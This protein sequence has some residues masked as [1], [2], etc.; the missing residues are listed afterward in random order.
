M[1]TDNPPADLASQ[2]LT[3]R[4][5]FEDLPSEVREGQWHFLRVDFTCPDGFEPSNFVVWDN[6]PRKDRFLTLALR[7]GRL[8]DKIPGANQ[9]YPAIKKEQSPS[10][11]WLRLLFEL[12]PS[13]LYYTGEE[14]PH[15]RVRSPG[16]W[17]G[18]MFFAAI[19]MSIEAIDKLGLL[20][21]E[22]VA[23]TNRHTPMAAKRPHRSTERGEART[24]IIPILTKHHQY[25]DGGCL[26]TEPIS[27]NELARQAGVSTSTAK[28]FF[29]KEFGGKEKEDGHAKYKVVCMN[30]GRLAD[31]IKAIRGEL[32]A[33]DLYGR[34]PAGEDNRNEGDE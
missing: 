30:A 27:I 3:L 18:G 31:S 16:P 17:K 33:H 12:E 32:R 5:Q 25:A 8:L 28:A 26:N 24:K 34:Q 20:V 14:K 7:A 29:D 22:H 15:W 11:R 13:Q 10:G 6:D 2:L 9:K 21:E 4:K 1:P 19:T 23:G